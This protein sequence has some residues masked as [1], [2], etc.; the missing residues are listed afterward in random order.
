MLRLALPY[1]EGL[2]SIPFASHW[3]ASYLCAMAQEEVSRW[4]MMVLRRGHS[5]RVGATSDSRNDYL[6][7]WILM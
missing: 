7:Y 2:V 4:Y 3:T 6:C 5:V 1:F